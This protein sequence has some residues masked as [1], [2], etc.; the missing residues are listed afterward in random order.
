MN[1]TQDTTMVM[2]HITRLLDRLDPALH[3]PCGVEGCT[4][5]HVS[6]TTPA[7]PAARR[8]HRRTRAARGPVIAGG[9]R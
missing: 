2:D 3:E 1:A 4:H 7:P 9:V 6:R 5:R 8:T